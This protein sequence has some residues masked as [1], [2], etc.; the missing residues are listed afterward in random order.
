VTVSAR[1][2][3]IEIAHVRSSPVRHEVRHR[4]YQWF[5]DLDDLPR[6]P[7]GLRWLA[8]FEARDHLGDPGRSLR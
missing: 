2:Y 7:R 8:R 4:S 1:L 6:L 3:E 5:V